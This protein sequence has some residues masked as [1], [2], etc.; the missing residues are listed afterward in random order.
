MG[1]TGRDGDLYALLGVARDATTAEIR[2][3]YE[4][5]INR[6]HRLGAI[7]HAAEI[8]KAFDTLSDLRRRE[9]Y[10]RYGLTPVR[11]RSPGAAPP[12]LPWRIAQ[13]FDGRV[14][15]QKRSRW[16]VPVTATFAL[17][18]AVGIALTVVMTHGG[19]HGSNSPGVTTVYTPQQILCQ[20][21]AGGGG[22]VY[23][24]RPGERPICTN[25]AVP[26]LVHRGS[27]D[28]LLE[29]IGGGRCLD[30]RNGR[31]VAC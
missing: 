15:S 29:P 5:E 19:S 3:A 1:E 25:G 24:S 16:R 12:P 10:D 17:G 7:R 11:E 21:A 8:S 2:W 6:A 30:T 13:H 4:R 18:L 28:P 22:Y 14:R 26:H 23:T 27:G 31:I 20:P 9:V